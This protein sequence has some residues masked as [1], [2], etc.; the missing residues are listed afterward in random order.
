LSKYDLF[1]QILIRFLI[2]VIA[3]FVLNNIIN[4]KLIMKK[5]LLKNNI[6]FFGFAIFFLGTFNE[7]KAQT[8]AWV[9]G[10]SSD[11]S[12][13]TNWNP[14]P[15]A[16]A[17]ADVFTIT[18]TGNNNNEV[19]NSAAVNCRQITL[20]TGVT[21]TT[22]ANVT[23]SSAATS[24]SNGILNINV[25]TANLPKLY[26]G[27]STSNPGVVNIASGA[28]LTGNNVWRVGANATAAGTININGGTLTL[29]T[30]GSLSLGYATTGIIN[31]NSG[32]LEVNYTAFSSF[33]INATNGFI[34]IDGGSFV[35][36]GD[37]TVAIAAFISGGRINVSGAALTAGKTLSNTY[38]SVTD[39]TT[40]IATGA[41]GTNDIVDTKRFSV[42]PNPTS[43]SINIATNT[44]SSGKLT[45][46]IYSLSGQKLLEKDF[47]DSSSNTNSIDI[48]GKLTSG[49]YL[50]KLTSGE[51]GYTSKI[52]IK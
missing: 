39:K 8:Y 27:N 9:G 24:S 17:T 23:T 19:V 3:S 22:G 5:V 13:L 7:T 43:D 31:I 14:A 47:S 38:D 18:A 34:N 50:I 4:T 20:G 25:G 41:L 6:L 12:T 44:D 37:Q 28:I 49:V 2:C 16:F 30:A 52:I 33:A 15:S 11:F 40:V 21:F 29:G 32:K 46:S 51:S 45:A 26:I 35:I 10:T 36:P 1:W 48:K 42:Y